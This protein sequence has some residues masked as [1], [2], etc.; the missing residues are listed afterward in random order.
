MT[1]P[2][3]MDSG[4]QIGKL[5]KRGGGIRP[6]PSPGLTRFSSIQRTQTVESVF[7]SRFTMNNI[8]PKLKKIWTHNFAF[9]IIS[10]LEK[11]PNFFHSQLST[12]Q[13]DAPAK[14]HF[15]TFGLSFMI[16][17]IAPTQSSTS[18]THLRGIW[19]VVRVKFEKKRRQKILPYQW[20]L[21]Y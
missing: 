21:P 10:K 4:L 5:H 16:N 17:F 14:F 15:S 12:L 1:S 7:I 20:C 8:A 3:F 19:M 18:C 9:K 11:L 13:K 2:N 6:P